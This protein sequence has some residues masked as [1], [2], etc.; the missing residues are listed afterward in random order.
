MTTTDIYQALASIT[1]EDVEG[2]TK[3]TM[4]PTDAAQ[5]NQLRQTVRERQQALES[6]PK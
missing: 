3:V 4:V 2:G 5:L 6:A 1:A